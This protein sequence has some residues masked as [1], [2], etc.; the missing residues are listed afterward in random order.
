[1]LKTLMKV[2]KAGSVLRTLRP[3]QLGAG[4]RSV[5][6]DGKLGDGTSATSGFYRFR[7]TATG[8]LGTSS[9]SGPF[10]VDRYTPRLS[11]PVTASVT[12]GR[13]ARIAYT[14][15]DPY[16]PTVKVGVTVKDATGATVAT[17]D[18]GW[19]SQGKSHECAWKPPAKKA[20]TLEFRALDRGGNH[21]NAVVRTK[22]TVR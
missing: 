3:G 17:L 20:Y 14:A 10:T 4:S 5:T 7:V 19:V 21:Q 16:S 9:V 22:L 12:L 6:W 15:R 13:T 8:A 1:M 11:A 2:S 18:L